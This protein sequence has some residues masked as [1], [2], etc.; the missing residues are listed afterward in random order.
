FW[1]PSIR[2]FPVA[3]QHCYSMLLGPPSLSIFYPIVCKIMNS[4]N[5]SRHR[6]VRV[7]MNHCGN[8]SPNV[9]CSTLG[10]LLRNLRCP[11]CVR[12]FNITDPPFHPI[13]SDRTCPN[14]PR[15]PLLASNRVPQFSRGM[16]H[17]IQSMVL[18]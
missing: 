17:V 6:N 3:P 9:T 2:L 14:L 18:H 13:I 12:L 5:N 10:V 4:F 1:Y 7:S 8:V 11:T 15:T 16:H